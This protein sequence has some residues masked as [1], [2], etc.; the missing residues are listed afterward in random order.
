MPRG[1]GCSDPSE[2][3]A[4]V[5][6]DIARLTK[7]L[8]LAPGPGSKEK[9]ASFVSASRAL[10]INL[11][12]GTKQEYACGIA[13]AGQ[14]F[15]DERCVSAG[16]TVTC[17]GLERVRAAAVAL[18]GKRSKGLRRIADQFVQRRIKRIAS[19]EISNLVGI[20]LRQLVLPEKVTVSPEAFNKTTPAA[21]RRVLLEKALAGHRETLI[22]LSRTFAGKCDQYEDRTS[23]DLLLRFSVRRGLLI[24]VKTL[25]GNPVETA[26]SALAQ[27]YE[28][29]Y[30]LDSPRKYGLRLAVCFDRPLGG[31]SWLL[32]F[33]TNDRGINVLWPL[34]STFV[35][36]G[37]DAGWIRRRMQ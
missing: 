37:P 22:S 31:P 2:E 26:R 10:G 27:I 33:L 15:W 29:R 3:K 6:R 36:R 19:E 8:Y 21:D 17:I 11:E 13:Q 20:R 28:Y 1:Q 4:D 12:R 25:G 34:D 35:I 9:K 5:L 16:D 7:T 32:P 24:E 14:Q 18:A 23:I 30:R